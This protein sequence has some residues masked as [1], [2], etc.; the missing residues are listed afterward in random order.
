MVSFV[1]EK[2]TRREIAAMNLSIAFTNRYVSRSGTISKLRSEFCCA[3]RQRSDK[4]NTSYG[5]LLAVRADELV[6]LTQARLI[7]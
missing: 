4:S 3:Q 2:P 6:T 5:L 1:R 7:V